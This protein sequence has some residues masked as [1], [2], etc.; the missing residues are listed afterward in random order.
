M[1]SKEKEYGWVDAFNQLL[2]AE[3]SQRRR[4]KEPRHTILRQIETEKGK[5][6]KAW[7]NTKNEKSPTSIS[8]NHHLSLHLTLVITM[9]HRPTF[10]HSRF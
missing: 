6:D 7:A 3:L 5:P 1:N 8:I 9:L 10:S 4:T 2:N